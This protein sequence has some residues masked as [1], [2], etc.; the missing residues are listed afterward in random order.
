M[1]MSKGKRERLRAEAAEKRAVKERATECRRADKAIA[2]FREN[3]LA[4]RPEDFGW[5]KQGYA[6]AKNSE[7]RLL[8]V[9]CRDGSHRVMTSRDRN[10]DR[11]NIATPNKIRATGFDVVHRDAGNHVRE[12]SGRLKQI[13]EDKITVTGPEGPKQIRLHQTAKRGTRVEAEAI[14]RERAIAKAKRDNA[15][16][17]APKKAK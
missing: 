14:Q 13:S 6:N 17:F 15:K 9:E 8:V 16:A 4:E 7:A 10:I 3:A 5:Y 1:A 11:T 12:T 2:R